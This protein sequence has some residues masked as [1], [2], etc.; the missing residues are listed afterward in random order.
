MIDLGV[1]CELC[2]NILSD[3]IKK[4]K[5]GSERLDYDDFFKEIDKYGVQSVLRKYG[6]QEFVSEPKPLWYY[7]VLWKRFHKGKLNPRKVFS[8]IFNYKIISYEYEGGR[9]RI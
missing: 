2:S 5:E 6:L 9:Q 3:M 1:D 4:S 8:E 7:M